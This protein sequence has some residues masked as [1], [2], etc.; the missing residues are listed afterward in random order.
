MFWLG[1]A[2]FAIII[3]VQA[4]LQPRA[5]QFNLDTYE[6]YEHVPN[7][8]RLQ[9]QLSNTASRLRPGHAK[10]THSCD[11]ISSVPN[12][13]TFITRYN[14]YRKYTEAYGIPVVSSSRVSDA[15]L[16]R[17][18]YIARFLFADR[19]D[20]RESMYKHFGRF[21]VIG[22]NEQ[23][24]TIPEFSHMPKWWDT[25]ARGLGGVLGRPISTG[26][27]E[28]LLCLSKDRYRGDDIFFHE[29]SHGVAEVAIRGGG[30]PGFY[31]RLLTQFNYV[32]RIGLWQNTYAM[33][34]SREYF[35][36]GMQSFF[37]CHIEADPPNGIHNRINTHQE[38]K[39][40]DPGLYNLIK[41]AYPCMNKYHTCTL[42]PPDM[43][44]NCDGSKPASTQA[45]SSKTT[46][47][48]SSNTTHATTVTTHAT[49]IATTKPLPPGKRV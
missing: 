29:A 3:D 26:G 28:N 48:P 39:A 49:T 32:K 13:L 41:E 38:L 4:V 7:N 12:D 20:V 35:A 11:V 14:Y 37:N 19:R 6:K 18:C 44:M 34:D 1:I 5:D 9:V 8:I 25:R 22:V 27:E 33:T 16:K 30:I 42:N 36:E 21:G 17:A 23:T 24:T 31:D 45:T 47:A 40:Y 43:R 2:F 15:A 10:D 46:H